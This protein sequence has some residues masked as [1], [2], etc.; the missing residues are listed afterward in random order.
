[1]DLSLWMTN[2]C[3]LTMCIESLPGWLNVLSHSGHLRSPISF[4]K[5][6][7]DL[8]LPTPIWIWLTWSFNPLLV[9]KDFVHPSSSQPKAPSSSTSFSPSWIFSSEKKRKSAEKKNSHTPEIWYETGL[10]ICLLHCYI[11][12]SMEHIL[13]LNT[14]W[15]YRFK[16]CLASLQYA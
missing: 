10:S 11:T 3:L 6:L 9:L 13:S 1:M 5:S 2:F 15:K 16:C 12:R 8:I 7:S 14:I 4:L